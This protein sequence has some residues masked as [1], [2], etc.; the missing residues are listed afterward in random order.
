MNEDCM[1]EGCSTEN[2]VYEGYM[3]ED[4][5]NED[6]MNE[7][8]MNEEARTYTSGNDKGSIGH[9]LGPA[10][11]HISTILDEA[12][13]QHIQREAVPPVCHVKLASS[14]EA[15]HKP[16]TCHHPTCTL[17]CDKDLQCE[18]SFPLNT[19]QVMQSSFPPY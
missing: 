9:A 2:C 7:D 19:K 5:I 8:Y 3:N 12:D 14:I 1:N 11:L 4:Y 17:G 10:A 15:T 13:G 16:P 18:T 6:Y